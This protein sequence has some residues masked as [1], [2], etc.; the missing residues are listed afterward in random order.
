MQPAA[1]PPVDE[2]MERR[3]LRSRLCLKIGLT[4]FGQ[5]KTDFQVDTNK[6]RESNTKGL[7]QTWLGFSGRQAGLKVQPCLS[8]C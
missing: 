7:K 8:E 4:G 6:E 2:N 3:A 1:A 5:P